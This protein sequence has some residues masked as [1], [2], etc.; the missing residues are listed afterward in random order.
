VGVSLFKIGTNLAGRS[1]GRVR[2]LTKMPWSL[3]VCFESYSRIQTGISDVIPYGCLEPS[4]AEQ[5]AFAYYV[6]L[7]FSYRIYY[8]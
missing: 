8:H 2:L 7:S 6:R 1:V 5:F 3:L 4:A